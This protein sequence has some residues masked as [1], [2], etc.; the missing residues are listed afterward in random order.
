MIG[1]HASD[2]LPIGEIV[3]LQALVL[4]CRSRGGHQE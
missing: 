4:R 3:Q 1:D 2:E